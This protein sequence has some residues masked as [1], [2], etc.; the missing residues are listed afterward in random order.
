[1]E[2]MPAPFEGLAESDREELRLLYQA[3]VSDI[4]LFTKQQW[5]VTNYALAFFAALLFIAY[6]P[7]TGLAHADWQ[8]WLLVV[9][10]WIITISG[11]AAVKRL[12]ISIVGGRRR[13][14]RTRASFGRPFQEVWAIPKPPDDVHR[15]LYLVM[16]LGSAVVTLLVVAKP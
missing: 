14:E 9:L 11:L 7:P 16:I 3:C 1:M 6:Q 2:S 13:L 4:A 8:S 15:L 10:A 5:S 12:Q